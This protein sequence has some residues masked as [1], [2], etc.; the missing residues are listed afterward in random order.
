[1]RED[2]VQKV[3]IFLVVSYDFINFENLGRGFESLKTENAR[4]S[5]Y[6]H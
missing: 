6:I 3:S 2:F 1:M 4:V 5:Q